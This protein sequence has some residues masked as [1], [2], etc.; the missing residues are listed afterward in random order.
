MENT[1]SYGYSR[2]SCFAFSRLWAHVVTWALGHTSLCSHAQVH[3]GSVNSAASWV[4]CHEQ[5]GFICLWA[6]AVRVPP[7]TAI[8]S[9]P[10][11]HLQLHA[12]SALEWQQ[13]HLHNQGWVPRG[14]LLELS[15][16][17]QAGRELSAPWERCSSIR[18]PTRAQRVAV[19]RTENPPLPLGVRNGSSYSDLSL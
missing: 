12:R 19:P 15:P 1:L 5:K 10:Y 17:V 11:L 3:C 7:R 8:P 6:E 9:L 14:L 16:P 13:L 4:W 18:E 2:L